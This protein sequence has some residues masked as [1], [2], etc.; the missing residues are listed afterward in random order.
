MNTRAGQKE[1]GRG[2]GDGEGEGGGGGV[3]GGEREGSLLH[4][5]KPAEG[6]TAEGEARSRGEKGTWV[7]S[8]EGGKETRKSWKEQRER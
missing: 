7:T 5:S 3:G 1:G 6:T 8:V 4:Y 2:E